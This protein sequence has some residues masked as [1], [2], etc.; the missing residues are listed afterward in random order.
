MGPDV[1]S[2]PIA[3]S[4]E[5]LEALAEVSNFGRTDMGYPGQ[6]PWTY[7]ILPETSLNEKIIDMSGAKSLP[8]VLMQYHFNLVSRMPLDH[9]IDILLRSGTFPMEDGFS[10]WFWM[11]S[12]L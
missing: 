10:I 1:I 9:R 11:V 4:S 5:H 6:G 12:L 8:L 2:L 7:C 3:T